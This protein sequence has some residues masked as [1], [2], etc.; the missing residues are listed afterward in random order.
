MRGIVHQFHQKSLWRCIEL[1]KHRYDNIFV[2]RCCK[3]AFVS[4]NR[5]S[6]KPIVKSV[7]VS[8][9]VFLLSN[10]RRRLP[11]HCLT[12][13]NA[14]KMIARQMKL[15]QDDSIVCAV[16]LCNKETARND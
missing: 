14:L 9:S 3:K 10:V 7:F 4:E 1:V 8:A 5:P 16:V 15:A 11:T 13:V 6:L 12:H 2:V